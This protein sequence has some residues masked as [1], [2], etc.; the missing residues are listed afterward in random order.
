MRESAYFFCKEFC[1]IKNLRI[2]AA[3]NV[4]ALARTYIYIYITIY[5]EPQIFRSDGI[6]C[7][8]VEMWL[9]AKLASFHFFIRNDG[10]TR[11]YMPNVYIVV[12]LPG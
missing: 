2:F 6:K 8:V 1:V 11:R 5:K 9:T 3:Q 7:I 10:L 4:G 12:V